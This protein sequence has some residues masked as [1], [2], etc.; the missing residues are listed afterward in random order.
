VCLEITG[1]KNSQAQYPFLTDCERKYLTPD[2][3]RALNQYSQNQHRRN[4]VY[5]GRTPQVERIILEDK[6]PDGSIDRYDKLSRGCHSL[7]LT[8]VNAQI[9]IGLAYGHRQKNIAQLL[10]VSVALVERTVKKLKQQLS[11]REGRVVRFLRVDSCRRLT[12]ARQPTSTTIACSEGE[13]GPG[14]PWFMEEDD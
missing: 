6:T 1:S 4:V 3:C 7:G 11:E 10:E 13:Y 5:E 12:P 14:C 2:Q 8:G 9:A